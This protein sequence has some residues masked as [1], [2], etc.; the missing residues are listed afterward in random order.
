MRYFFDN[1]TLQSHQSPDNDFGGLVK[2]K[3][4][5]NQEQALRSKSATSHGLSSIFLLKIVA[6]QLVDLRKHCLF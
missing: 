4:Q 6:L 5:R 2:I 3:G 1:R